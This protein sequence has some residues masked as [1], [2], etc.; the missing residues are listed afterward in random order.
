MTKLTL[1]ESLIMFM[2][3]IAKRHD[4]HSNLI[5]EIQAST[6][7]TLRN[8]QAMI[9]ALEIQVKQ[10][11]IIL[12]RNLSRNLQSSTEVK[13]IVNDEMISTSVKT[14]MPSICRIDASQYAVSNLQ[15]K[16]LFFD[17]KKTTLPSPSRLNDDYWDELKETDGE[18]DLEAHYT[19]A[20]PL[21][22]AF[23]QKD[24]DP[25]SFTLSCFI[26]HMCFNKALADLGA[27]VSVMPYSTYTT[28]GLGDLIPTKLIFELADRIVK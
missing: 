27:S 19:N 22:K 3:K 14:D 6:D 15:N 4:E 25:R 13:P 28:L 12:P 9:K 11:S 2:V 23:P 26:N 7:F 17:S 20:K 24:K 10:I 18:K 1:E 16:N 5:K 8:Q 21:G